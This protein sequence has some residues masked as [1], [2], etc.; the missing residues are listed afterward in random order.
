MR[1]ISVLVATTFLAGLG[2]GSLTRTAGTGIPGRT[3][4]R[5]VDLADIEKLHKADVDAT[6]TQ[7]PKQLTI[8]WS[9]DAVNLQFPG[10]AVV[11]IKAM[12]GA[13]EKFRAENPDFKV[14]KYAPDIKDVQ[15]TADGWAIEWGYTEATYQVSSSEKPISMKGK[16]LRVL[17]RQTDGSWKFA[18]IASNN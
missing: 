14:L 10:P 1:G 16:V 8:L 3:D 5:G 6:L 13:Y 9:D 17:K 11:G 15:V 12:Q 2:I 4:T 18:R 7:D